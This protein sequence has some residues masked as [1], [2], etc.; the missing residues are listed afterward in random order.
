MDLKMNDGPSVFAKYIEEGSEKGPSE[1]DIVR[2][3]PQPIIPPTYSQSTP[4]EQLLDFLVN[5]WPEPTINLRDICKYGPNFIRQNRRNAIALT[6]T[7][8]RHGWLIPLA[9]HQRNMKKWRIV[10][11]PNRLMGTSNNV[12]SRRDG[13]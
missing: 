7:L 3:G 12:G 10:R 6:E 2:R 11:A 1:P 9:A 4:I 13:N 8:A 5:H